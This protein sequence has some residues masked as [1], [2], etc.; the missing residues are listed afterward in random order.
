MD[1]DAYVAAH[2]HEWARL[3]DLV[4]RGSKLRGT[5]ADELL[6]LYQRTATHLSEI[7]STCPDPSVVAHLSSLLARARSC[8]GGSRASSWQDFIRF[9]MTT[10][11]AALYR[12][13]RWWLV[14]MV[15]FVAVSFLVGWYFYVNP[16]LESTLASPEEI[17]ELVTHDFENYYS[18][19][20]AGSFAFRVWTNNA[21]IA[22]MCIA[23]GV[24]GLPVV[25]LLWDNLLNIAI[26]GALMWRYDRADLFFGLILPHGMLELT[27]VF[28]AAGVGLRVFWSWVEPG[29]RSRL[30]AVAH[31]ARAA[32]SVALGLIVVLFVTGVIEGFVTPSPL[33]TW[34]RIGIGI[35]AELLFFAYVFIVGRQAARA[36]ATGDVDAV[37]QGD[38]APVAG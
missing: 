37:D 1:L 9:F 18:E 14:T 15:T 10:F 8:A 35:W 22:A 17:Q 29:P 36:G 26:I 34:V 27:A 23:L 38:A 16:N 11:P 21:F 2:A 33:P 30:T 24:F 7:R 31:E 5:E 3:E 13:R 28:V 32:M 19:Y 12:T 6:E 25:W 20:A 4:K